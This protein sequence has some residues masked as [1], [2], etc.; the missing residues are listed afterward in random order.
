MKGAEAYSLS[1]YTRDNEVWK[2]GDKPEPPRAATSA[3]PQ[4]LVLFVENFNQKAV[5]EARSKG[6][7][8]PSPMVHGSE[9]MM[10]MNVDPTEW[11]PQLFIHC[12]VRCWVYFSVD[13]LHGHIFYHIVLGM[14]LWA[15]VLVWSFDPFIIYIVDDHVSFSKCARF[16]LDVTMLTVRRSINQQK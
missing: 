9:T 3:S 16:V 15:S 14:Q 10:S 7:Q 2:Y 1:R 4:F 8:V 11:D 6:I 12:Q 13:Y 5:Q